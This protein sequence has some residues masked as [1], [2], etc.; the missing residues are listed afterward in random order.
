MS[1]ADD[2]EAEL[3][4]ATPPAA[5][6]APQVSVHLFNVDDDPSERRNLATEM[7]AKVVRG[8]WTG[9]AQRTPRPVTPRALSWSG[10][11]AGRRWCGCGRV[12]VP[13]CVTRVSS[14]LLHDELA[15]AR[16]LPS[17]ALTSHTG[18]T[19][20]RARMQAELRARLDAV[21]LEAVEATIMTHTDPSYLMR[22]LVLIAPG[23]FAV[24]TWEEH[25]A[26]QQA[27]QSPRGGGGADEGEEGDAPRA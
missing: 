10:L 27:Q 5:E 3:A 21:Q 22:D 14:P 11:Q 20:I 23:Q 15:H 9:A 17:D 19:R 4:G 13:R 24:G 25:D 18:A 7:P 1:A 16:M 2:L 6:A 12:Q 26:A 8:G